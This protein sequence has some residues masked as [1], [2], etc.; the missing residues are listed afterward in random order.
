MSENLMDS[1]IVD[2]EVL[3][4]ALNQLMAITVEKYPEKCKELSDLR[5]NLSVYNFGN[6]KKL[7]SSLGSTLLDLRNGKITLEEFA[8]VR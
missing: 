6:N 1:D 3:Y 4:E 2:F 5:D 8:S 7:L